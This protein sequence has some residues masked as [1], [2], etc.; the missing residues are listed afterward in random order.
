MT[1]QQDHTIE[2]D[3][4]TFVV[5]KLD[6]LEAQDILIDLSH[7]LAKPAGRIVGA[8]GK[9]DG[10]GAPM[11]G[12]VAEDE[13]PSEPESVFDLDVDLDKLGGGIEALMLSLDKQVARRIYH[14]LAKVSHVDGKKVAT[15]GPIIFAQNLGLMYRWEWFALRAQFGNFT[16]IGG[17][18]GRL[19]ELF[20]GLASRSTS[21]DDGS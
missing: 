5:H 21:P 12:E 9:G 6:P 10:S 11:P 13:A 18:L 3:G 8:F 16:E 2:L 7:V 17:A 19:V 15:V 20:K 14:A 1:Q 4:L